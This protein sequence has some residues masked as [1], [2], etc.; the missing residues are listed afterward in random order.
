MNLNTPEGKVPETLSDWWNRISPAER[1]YWLKMI[2]SPH[3]SEVMAEFLACEIEDACLHPDEEDRRA[4]ALEW[5]T[6]QDR[7]VFG[8]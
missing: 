1:G 3:I 7:D 2:D 4:A 5:E 6:K 8:R